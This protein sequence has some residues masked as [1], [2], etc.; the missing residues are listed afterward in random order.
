MRTEL[1]FL[2]GMMGSG[3][4]TVGKALARRLGRP[5]FDTDHEIVARSGVSIPTIFD[6]EGEA[7][8]RRRE[9][10]VLAEL[11]QCRE[12]VI[13]TGGGVVLEADNRRLM[14]ESG[15]VVYLQVSID[16]LH[17]RTARDTSRPLL[18]R[19]A[20]RRATLEALLAQ[21]DPL[22]REA[23]HDVVEGGASSAT[24]LAFRIAERLD[25]PAQDRPRA[26]L[27]T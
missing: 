5:F 8:F 22:Y 15:T 16:H 3:K 19:S 4:T 7:G 25:Q 27:P 20:D 9:S 26:D 17:Q 13:A 21:R 12:A 2:V 6:I 11:A 14:R 23:A 10:A 1:I 18:A 24:A